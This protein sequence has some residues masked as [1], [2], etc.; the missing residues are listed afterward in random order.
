MPFHDSWYWDP[1]NL[2][3]NEKTPL[4]AS[5]FDKFPRCT[6]P[7]GPPF[8]KIFLLKC[9]IIE[10][11]IGILQCTSNCCDGVDL[12]HGLGILR[13]DWSVEA[14]WF[15]GT[16]HLMLEGAKIKSSEASKHPIRTK[17]IPSA[18]TNRGKL[19]EQWNWQA[20]ER[21][22]CWAEEIAGTRSNQCQRCIYQCKTATRLTRILEP[23]KS[24]TTTLMLKLYQLNWLCTLTGYSIS[25]G[26][27]CALATLASL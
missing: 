8:S 5:E 26:T 7:I 1:L 22:N 6:P 17:M 14:K 9:T 2:E 18:E 25:P 4:K 19:G 10:S 27:S 12:V 21:V 3:K 20:K 15:Y 13:D 23:L 11:L 24:T 16:I